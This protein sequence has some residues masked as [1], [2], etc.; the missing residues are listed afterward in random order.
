MQTFSLGLVTVTTAGTRV[1]LASV[2]PADFPSNGKCAAIVVSPPAS[3]TG[4]AVF[5]T[6][7]VIAASLVGVVKEF[8][9]PASTG[10][11]DSYVHKDVSNEGNPIN[12]NDYALD[13]A[14]NGE[15]LIVAIVVR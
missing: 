15:G 3:N 13:V 7:A 8:L 4:K 14:V 1:P 6:T 10:A 11:K 9:P 2:L 5:G 12:A